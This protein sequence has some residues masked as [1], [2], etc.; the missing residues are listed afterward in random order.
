LG[1]ILIILMH[2]SNEI[3]QLLHPSLP[4]FIRCNQQKPSHLSYELSGCDY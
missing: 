4:T 1:G 2:Y 3:F